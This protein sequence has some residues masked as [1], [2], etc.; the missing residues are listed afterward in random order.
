MIIGRNKITA[1][2]LLLMI[3]AVFPWLTTCRQATE[4][5]SYPYD[6]EE[7]F[8][9]DT[10]GPEKPEPAHPGN[11]SISPPFDVSEIIEQVHFAFTKE[12][13]AYFG[14]HYSHA[15]WIH[16]DGLITF[17]PGLPGDE[18][19]HDLLG[20]PLEMRTKAIERDGMDSLRD[21]DPAELATP[22][23]VEL[24]R[25]SVVEWYENRPDGLEQGWTFSEEPAGRG[26]LTI[27]LAVAGTPFVIQTPH[28]L[29]FFD[30]AVG[31]GVRYGLGIW[32]DAAGRET[33]VDPLFDGRDIV[34]R[35][36]AAVLR[37]AA[38]PA[39]LDPTVSTEFE[40]DVPIYPPVTLSQ[41]QPTVAST[42]EMYLVAWRDYRLASTRGYDI[43][44]TR[45]SAAG[46]VLDPSGLNLTNIGAAQYE[47]TA[48]SNGTTFLVAWTDM[49]FGT[50]SIT[51]KRLNEDGDILD[52]GTGIIVFAGGGTQGHPAAASDGRNY[53]V[54]WED[55]RQ[56]A[57]DVLGTRINAAGTV[58]D[59]DGFRLTN[60][61][62]IQRYGD[63]EFDGENYLIVWMD[64][65]NYPTTKFDI[66][67]TRVTTGGAILDTNGFL[68]SAAAADEKYPRAAA[69]PNDTLVVWEDNRNGTSDIYGARVLTDGTTPDS[70]GLPLVVNSSAALRPVA[71]HD[72]LNYLVVWNDDRTG[73]HDI[74]GCRVDADGTPLDGEG[75]V[76]DDN[77]QTQDLAA[78]AFAGD[79]ALVV[80]EDYS[81]ATSTNWDIRARLVDAEANVT[82]TLALAVSTQ[83]PANTE[84]QAAVAFDG[85][86]YLVVWRDQRYSGDADIYGSRVSTA[87]EILDPFSLE[88][89]AETGAQSA[90][91]VAFG[92]SYYLVVW[93]DDR[94]GDSDIYAARVQTDG[95]SLDAAG[96]AVSGAVNDQTNPA[97]TFTGSNYLVV[98]QDRRSGEDNIYGAQVTQAGSVMQS[99]GIPISQATGSQSAPAAAAYSGQYLAAWQDER[100]GVADIYAARLAS[101]GG[102]QDPAGLAV[103]TATGAQTLP[104]ATGTSSGYLIAWQDE[105]NGEGDIYAGR[106]NSAGAVLDADGFAVCAAAGAQ[107]EPAVTYDG[108]NSVLSWLDYRNGQADLY[109]T[110]IDSEGTILLAEEMAIDTEEGDKQHLTV[111]A[112][113]AGGSLIVYYKDDES[114]VSRLRARVMSWRFVGAACASDDDCLS[115][116][117]TDGFCCNTRCG[118]GDPTDCQVCAAGEGAVADGICT[119]RAG[120]TVNLC[121]SAAGVCD[122]AEYCDGVNGECPADSYATDSTVCRAASDVCDAAEYCT[123]ASVSCPV[124]VAKPATE[125][126]RAKTDLCDAVEYCNGVSK[127]C[128]A[129]GVASASTVCR[130]V[131]DECDVT[132]Y[133]D[134]MNKECPTDAYQTAG[135]VCREQG[136][137]C[138]AVETC[139]GDSAACP[140]DG[141]QT[142]GVVCRASAGVCDYQEVC[143]G[144]GPLCPPDLLLPA[145]EMCRAATGL[146]DVAEYCTGSAVSCPT[147]SVAPSTS[148]CRAAADVC[149]APEYC[150][151]TGKD[152][153]SDFYQVNTVECRPVAG[154]CDVAE[155]CTGFAVACPTDTFR[156]ATVECRAIQGVCD[157]AE[158]CAGD[159][160]ACPTDLVLSTD[161]ECR[162]VAAEC[163]VADYCD[164]VHVGC[165]VDEVAPTSRAC[166]A[167]TDLCDQVDYCDGVQTTCPDD[168]VKPTTVECRTAAGACDVGEYCDGVGKTCPADQYASSAKECR[169]VAGLCDIAEYCTGASASCPTDFFAAPTVVCRASAGVCDIAEYCTGLAAT[170][171][172]DAFQ[173]MGLLCREAA[174]VCDVLESCTGFSPDCP[175]D[176]MLSG[177]TECRAA[178]GLCDAVEYCDAVHPDCPTDAVLPDTEVC[179]GAV[180][181]CDKADLCNGI[182]KDCPADVYEPASTVCRA[183][184]GDC[185]RVEYCTGTLATCP[186]DSYRP[187]TTQCRAAVDVC[188]A[189]EFCPGDGP[190]CPT[191]A[192]APA[193]ASCRAATGVCDVE[194]YCTGAGAT[195]PADARQPVTVE[196]RGAADLCDAPEFC[197][198][199]NADCPADAVQ[200]SDWECRA[201][202]GDC[203]APDYCDGIDI[204]CP[205]DAYLPAT[206]QCR[207]AADVCDAAEYCSGADPDCPADAFA[208]AATECRAAADVCDVAES[209]P[210][211]GPACPA[212]A[213]AST[214][215]ECR[216]AVDVCDAA[217]FC[218]GTAAACPADAMQPI[219]VRC[220][221]AT[222]RC[223]APEFCDAVH[224]ECPV[225]AVRPTTWECRETA[226]ECDAPDFC[227]GINAACPVDAYLPATT[228]CRA[229]T[230]ACD[231]AEYCSGADPDCPADVFAPA[232][233]E[234]RPVAGV[235]D[236]AEFCTGNRRS[237]PADAFLPPTAECRPATGVCDLPEYCTGQEA[238]CPTDESVPDGESCD[239][240]L[241][242][243]GTDI[244]QDGEC[245]VS[246]GN[247]CG[248]DLFCNGQEYCSEEEDRCLSVDPPQCGN[249]GL[250]CNGEE[251]CNEVLDRCEH[252]LTPILRC[253][254]DQLYCNGQ[255]SCDDSWDV[256]VHSGDPC[257]DD[258]LWC[259]G[260]ESCDEELDM[261]LATGNPCAAGEECVEAVDE[262]VVPEDNKALDYSPEESGCG[263]C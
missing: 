243:N 216:A 37:E 51:A 69:G 53:F 231:A 210:G 39:V 61:S 252:T 162:P 239:D 196:C 147:D 213:F 114:L 48:T 41:T 76:I 136:G 28:G 128:P 27:R 257:S 159:A 92:G 88:I 221:A 5:D 36:P 142:A 156:P 218:T 118:G 113:G 123:G 177:E 143:P 226:G 199:V 201:A 230:G 30:S 197:D 148:V 94:N 174:G 185:D 57:Y 31:V 237:C 154:A 131:A 134:G 244:C 52:T 50:T 192:F 89:C 175:A 74:Y 80:W 132:D 67:G 117:C 150:T 137:V 145:T 64:A 26:D 205:A 19:D 263:S 40:I 101:S 47:P 18:P 232:T 258:G 170:C 180:G 157:V 73:N 78:V 105:R 87:G 72:G 44:A 129:D 21:P 219:S 169:S 42:G 194:E 227:D 17:L 203:D 86:N 247:P 85:A 153:P 141:Y 195:C 248:D 164:G 140:T 236:S 38:Y 242:C 24:R 8:D 182:H 146:C 9:D 249:D 124:D 152:C 49:Q 190:A 212:D 253:P 173:T 13:N 1:L 2:I 33:I 25:D 179:R 188:D 184:A 262:C 4:S 110:Y 103:C 116:Y 35:V 166:R 120:G 12:K 99:N 45:V 186:A 189:A 191:D 81:N 77:T 261:C 171:P 187:A 135:V 206:T 214:G 22:H 93:A 178:S 200:P 133:C 251:Y 198:A 59:E 138:D 259:N 220:R 6:N 158:Y 256:C 233:T 7:N 155:Y 260:E 79:H 66:Y 121:R 71:V 107:Q 43:F 193:T 161:T 34:L 83:L 96:F 102:V 235:C 211:D 246:E 122:V 104:A 112:D 209:C 125:V 217:E 222:D 245:M 207:A 111:A 144:D 16:P 119:P 127:V 23:R 95:S 151:G 97:V 224:P 165:P 55:D 250:W 3:S 167:A 100:N 108:E 149:D 183:A 240:G 90:P 46:A 255:E 75:F 15:V 20:L 56:S 254:D 238:P 60:Q 228:E 84:D 70:D 11:L 168:Q 229:V 14:G 29:H 215:V 234:C 63:V 223:D 62:A 139:T 98:W 160:A 241:W 58:L 106:L 10:H 115:G 126:C 172:V 176:V 65:R 204:A 91:A 68:V 130:E 181:V 202:A 32:R 82:P 208:P 109:G 163:D 54:T 225:D